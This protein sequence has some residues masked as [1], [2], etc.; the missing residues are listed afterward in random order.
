MVLCGTFGSVENHLLIKNY[1]SLLHGF[2][3]IVNN[4]VWVSHIRHPN[5]IP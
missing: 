2:L 1:C 5:M 4:G 3:G